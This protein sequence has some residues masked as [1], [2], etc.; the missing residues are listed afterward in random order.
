[1][2]AFASRPW[3]TLLSLQ[4]LRHSAQSWRDSRCVG[5]EGDKHVQSREECS[6]H[7]ADPLFSTLEVLVTL[8]ANTSAIPPAPWK[9][10][11]QASAYPDSLLHTHLPSLD[12]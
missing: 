8:M 6:A 9:K 10:L 5:H 12:T 7:S 3:H 1:M 4:C 2:W 11:T